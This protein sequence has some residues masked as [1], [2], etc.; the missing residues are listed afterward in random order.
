MLDL[1]NN[2]IEQLLVPD[3]MNI[4]NLELHG[5][6]KED[7]ERYTPSDWD[8]WVVI[9]FSGGVLQYTENLSSGD[10]KDLPNAVSPFRISPT[11][12]ARRFFR[13]LPFEPFY[14]KNISVD[15]ANQVISWNSIPSFEY[16][17]EAKVH[18]EDHW[19]EIGK[20]VA[21]SRTTVWNFTHLVPGNYQIFRIA[22]NSPIEL[23][24]EKEY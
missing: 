9:V 14:Q 20:I 2:P 1:R 13:V 4:D 18:P 22:R 12:A 19:H 7:I 5:F 8:G 16:H 21:D 23:S 6:S 24:I 3:G 15:L 10:W 11:V 17:I